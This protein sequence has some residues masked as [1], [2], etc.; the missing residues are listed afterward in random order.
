MH[1]IYPVV[2]SDSKI[3]KKTYIA[4][5]IVKDTNSKKLYFSFWNLPTQNIVI[6][7]AL[8]KKLDIWLELLLKI[9]MQ[10]FYKRNEYKNSL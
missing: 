3:K 5:T 6:Y 1:V 4:P 8:Y 9:M 10:Y 2:L 7:L